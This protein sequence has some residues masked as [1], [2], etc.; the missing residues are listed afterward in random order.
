VRDAATPPIAHSTD[1]STRPTTCP[2]EQPTY[3]SKK[4]SEVVRAS[5]AAAESAA[6]ASAPTATVPLMILRFSATRCEWPIHCARK[7]S[8]QTYTAYDAKSVR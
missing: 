4:L 8:P 5:A 6:V 2:S 7:T 1:E 3:V